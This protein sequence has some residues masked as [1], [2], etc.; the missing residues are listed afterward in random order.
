MSCNVK[1]D[2]LKINGM[3]KKMAYNKKHEAFYVTTELGHIFVPKE[4]FESKK[5]GEYLKNIELVHKIINVKN[6]LTHY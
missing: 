6:K 5:N 2:K 3:F 1:I 4:I